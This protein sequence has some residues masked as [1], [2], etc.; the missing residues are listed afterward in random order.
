MKF[1]LLT[2]AHGV[3]CTKRTRLF[4]CCTL[5]FF[6][7]LTQSC[8]SVFF[9]TVC[10]LSLHGDFFSLRVTQGSLYSMS[11][12]W[13]ENQKTEPWIEPW[14]WQSEGGREEVPRA[15]EEM[16]KQ[17]TL[18]E[19]AQRIVLKE[20]NPWLTPAESCESDETEDEGTEP[21]R[22]PLGLLEPPKIGEATLGWETASIAKAESRPRPKLKEMKSVRTFEENAECKG[23][24]NQQMRLSILSWNAGTNRR[25]VRNSMIGSFHVVI[26]QE[27]ETHCNKIGKN[28]E[29]QFYI[30]EEAD[31]LVLCCKSTFELEGV[32]I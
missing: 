28:A 26:I 27:A 16:F 15:D 29:Q 1:F 30:Y 2:T 19:P 23:G 21:F 8:K 20:R 11:R 3:P 10:H 14:C 9:F 12:W 6:D 18:T 22:A 7:G 31:Q 24:L 5:D 13:K 32:K 25:E 4:L 17:L